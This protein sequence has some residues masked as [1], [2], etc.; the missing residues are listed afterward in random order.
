M[1]TKDNKDKQDKREETHSEDRTVTP[2]G[3]ARR[4]VVFV[5]LAALMLAGAGGWISTARAAG[6]GGDDAAEGEGMPMRRMHMILDRVG[7]T[8]GQR[9]QIRAI[10]SGL[11][12]QLRAE[13]A[14]HKGL[15]EQMVAALTAPTINAGEVERLR[16][17]TMA[18]TD[19][20]SALIT[21]G[22]IA[23]AQVLT[24]D[25]RKLAQQEIAKG[26]GHHHWGPGMP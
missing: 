15:R 6:P 14:T 11:R 22:M 16:K 4:K 19:K 10:W 20:I 13:R 8:A 7:A 3:R 24:P 2:A 12:P 18:N 23:S 5:S 1:Q 26:G 17:L 9:D 21:Q 25:Q